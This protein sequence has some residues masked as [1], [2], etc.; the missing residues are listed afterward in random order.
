MVYGGIGKFSAQ[1]Q[2]LKG[3]ERNESVHAAAHRALGQTDFTKPSSANPHTTA[4][5]RVA[6]SVLLPL[7]RSSTSP[8]PTSSSPFC[9]PFYPSLFHFHL[10]LASTVPSLLWVCHYTPSACINSVN[11][12]P[13]LLDN[14]IFRVFDQHPFDH[15]TLLLP[16]R[17]SESFTLTLISTLNSFRFSTFQYFYQVSTSHSRICVQHTPSIILLP[18]TKAYT[19]RT[20]IIGSPTFLRIIRAQTRER[21]DVYTFERKRVGREAGG[22]GT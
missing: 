10:D 4:F 21:N 19:Y 1:C 22:R 18:S 3:G 5:T 14:P 16:A 12:Q 2:G 9:D 13:T 7:L 17:Y 11:L 15:S 8:T 6:P 20:T